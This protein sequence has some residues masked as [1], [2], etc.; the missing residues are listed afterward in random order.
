MRDMCGERNAHDR[1]LVQAIAFGPGTDV[2]EHDD[3]DESEKRKPRDA[4]LSLGQNEGGEQ[5]AQRRA[6]MA[7]DLKERLRHAVLSAGSHARD[8]GGFGMK[9]GGAGAD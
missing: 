3:G 6:S 9:Y 2:G 7:T 4:G 1:G 5:R 8:A